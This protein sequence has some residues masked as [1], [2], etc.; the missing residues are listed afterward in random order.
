MSLFGS[1]KKEV[2]TDLNPTS[3]ETS[4]ARIKV[5]GTGCTKCKALNNA[6]QEAVKE[7]GLNEEVLYVTDATQI[8]MMG[9]MSTPALVIN[10]KVVSAGKSLE[11]AQVIKFLQKSFEA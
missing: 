5:L 11:K 8:A 1:R 3:W 2:A 9:V 6:T 4:T 10:N 7:L